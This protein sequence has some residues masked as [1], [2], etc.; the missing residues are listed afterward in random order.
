MREIVI[1]IPD[2]PIEDY[3]DLFYKIHG[4]AASEG[5][6]DD[7]VKSQRA[8]ALKVVLDILDG[9]VN[10][11]PLPKGHGRLI[12]EPTEEE[13]AE[14]IGGKNDFADCI[15]EAVKTVFTN[16]LTIIEADKAASE[17]TDK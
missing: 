12:T 6:F 1:K 8:L 14:T 15:R 3:Q 7:K 13:I 2:A 10:G 5:L 9:I 11:I 17:K 16:A 4:M